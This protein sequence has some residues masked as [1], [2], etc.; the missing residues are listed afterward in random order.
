MSRPLLIAPSILAADFARLGE[1]VRAV[2]TAGADWIHIDV[3]DGHFVPNISIGP[4]VVKALR[5]HTR[6]ML[7][8]HL[9]I[10]PCDPY[11]EAFARAGSDIITV[12]VEAGP[13][14]HRSLQTI[15]A[16]G[17]RAGVTINP[18]TPVDTIEPL[19]D[20]IDLVLVMSV[21]PGFGGQ[22]FIPYAIEKIARL[23]AMCGMREIDIEVDGGITP[24]VAPG[25][26]SGRKRA[27]SRVSHLQGW[28]SV[29][30]IA[31]TFLGQSAM[32]RR[33]PAERWHD[34]PKFLRGA[35]VA[36]FVS[37]G[38]PASQA[39]DGA[40]VNVLGFSRDG[41]YFALNNMVRKTGQ[42]AST[43]R[44]LRSRLPA[45]GRSKAPPSPRRSV[46]RN[47]RAAR[48]NPARQAAGE[49]A[50]L[51][52]VECGAAAEKTRDLRKGEESSPRWLR[53]GRGSWS[54]EPVKS[55]KEAAVNTLTLPPRSSAQHYLVLRQFDI[56]L[57]A[58]RKSDDG[59]TSCRIWPDHRAQG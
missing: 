42:A 55:A 21:N 50:H 54:F 14:I 34:G 19:V 31:P 12:H 30:F 40:A 43:L 44:L 58:V 33:W 8:V 3:M 46:A 41:H 49:S 25:R 9:M 59:G 23:R 38:G 1:E 53:A 2:D 6:K 10:A 22:G 7:D 47:S 32:Q 39:G 28:Q 26:S 11:L 57:E 29:H 51:G 36:L 56:A 52:G 5:P 20:L 15:R 24:E 18:G 37:T 16:L 17:K 4:E 45:T 35:I 48:A 27:C 13:H